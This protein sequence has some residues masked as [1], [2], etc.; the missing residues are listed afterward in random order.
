MEPKKLTRS[1]DDKWFAGVC[2]GLEDYTGIDSTLWRIGAVVATILTGV[3]PTVIA[4][5]I[6]WILIPK[7][8][9][10]TWTQA[11]TAPPPPPSA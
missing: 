3:F 6:G 2:G 5:F 9:K 1:R 7:Q 8:A 4:Y 10:V 11:T